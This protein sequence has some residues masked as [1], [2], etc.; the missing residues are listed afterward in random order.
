MC[1]F[2]RRGSLSSANEMQ[3]IL[4]IAICADLMQAKKG[5][6]C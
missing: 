1:H 5:D 2:V 4:A 6:R 3:A